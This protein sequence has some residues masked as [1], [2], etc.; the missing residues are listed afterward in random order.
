M[1]ELFAYPY[2]GLKSHCKARGGGA[3]K[4]K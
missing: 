1:D 3:V 2:T 4:A